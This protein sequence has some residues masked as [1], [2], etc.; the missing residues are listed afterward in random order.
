MNG[1]VLM[2]VFNEI[3]YDGRVQR[4]AEA[5]SQSYQ[6]TVYSVN[7]GKGYVHPEY[8]L[9][10]WDRPIRW[11]K[12]HFLVFSLWFIRQSIQNR[13]SLIYAHDYFMA[14]PG[15]LAAKLTRSKF[16]YDAHELIIPDGNEKMG[17]RQKIF[18]LLESWVVR[19][20]SRVV[21]ANKERADLMKEYYS[22]K[23]TPLVIR[24]IPPIS[25]YESLGEYTSVLDRYKHHE[26]AI[27]LV[28]QGDMSLERGLKKFILAFKYLPEEFRLFLIGGG[29][30]A[31]RIEE[32]I[33]KEKLTDR[34]VMLG[35][36]P[37]NILPGLLLHFDVGIISY[38]YKGLNNIYCA[39]NK[40]YE[41]AQ[42]GLPVIAT[43]QPPL[44]YYVSSYEIG[45]IAEKE[46]G[47]PDNDPSQIASLIR[48]MNP[49]SIAFFKS[50]LGAFIR[51]HTWENEK[52]VLLTDMSE[53][54][55]ARTG[56]NYGN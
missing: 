13:G 34:I 29:T 25:D 36:V 18:Y 1:K 11:K 42:A 46:E 55:Y 41:Y 45:L 16:I 39:P 30:D 3:D 40:L 2:P 33:R 38:P 50:N 31:P 26:S 22:L 21:A 5:L 4:A 32:L 9:E 7:S 10:T 49:E 12:I 15:W 24:N 37:R 27:K 23:Q 43:G 47:Q 54:S 44:K 20:A 53:L 51:E 14:F 8:S 35:K 48:E 17:R 6:V 19:R 56:E 52:A 28:Y